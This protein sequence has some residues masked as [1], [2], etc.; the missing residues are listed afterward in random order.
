METELAN[1]FVREC[2]I[3]EID[4]I[5]TAEYCVFVKALRASLRLKQEFPNRIVKLRDVDDNSHLASSNRH[6][7]NSAN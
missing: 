2:Y 1:D 7:R 6:C 4:G 3:V 5:A